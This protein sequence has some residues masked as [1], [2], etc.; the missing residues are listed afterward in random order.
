MDRKPVPQAYLAAFVIPI[1][2]GIAVGICAAWGQIGSAHAVGHLIGMSNSSI[3]AS[4]I[5]GALLTF[6]VTTVL[7]S[8][9]GLVVWVVIGK[10]LGYELSQDQKQ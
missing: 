10:A 9:I 3:T 5:F 4:S 6:F 2:I 7:T 1:L 8:F